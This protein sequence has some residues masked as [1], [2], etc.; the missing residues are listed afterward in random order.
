MNQ[1]LI[2]YNLNRHYLAE[3]WL[4]QHKQK[5]ADIWRFTLFANELNMTQHGE[6]NANTYGNTYNH[7]YHTYKFY[8]LLH[9]N[10][11]NP[12]RNHNHD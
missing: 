2:K 12:T 6:N 3:K 10:T 11:P 4:L 9:A 7:L 1:E 5:S 8:P